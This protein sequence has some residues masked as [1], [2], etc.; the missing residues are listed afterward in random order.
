M[1][2]EL[3]V[4]LGDKVLIKTPIE[5]GQERNVSF[6][7]NQVLEIQ[8]R[9][10]LTEEGLHEIL[11]PDPG[12][13]YYYYNAANRLTYGKY[14]NPSQDY[15]KPYVMRQIIDTNN[16]STNLSNGNFLTDRLF[17]RK[18]KK[19]GAGKRKSRRTRRTNK[20]KRST[21]RRTRRH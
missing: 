9:E 19:Y 15:A 12:A 10:Q 18:I 3:T 13:D 14:I 17:I 6:G 7:Q 11:N 2:R 5:C 21:K 20:R 4:L 1:P 16:G 8:N